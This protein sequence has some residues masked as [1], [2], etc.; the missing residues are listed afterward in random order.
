MSGYTKLHSFVKSSLMELPLATRWLWAFMLSEA[1]ADGIVEGAVN[2]LAYA[3]RITLE[4]CETAL[5]TF[6]DPDKYSRTKELDGRRLIEVDG[7]W[8]IVSYR[9]W[10]H[11]FSVEERAEYKATKQAEYRARDAKAA[12]AAKVTRDVVRRLK[13]TPED[14]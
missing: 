14:E 7:G 4:E 5:A 9:K 12:A 10:R 11:K 8:Q 6:L 1:D 3:A 2:G 13:K